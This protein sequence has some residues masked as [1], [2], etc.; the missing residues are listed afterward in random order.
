MRIIC[1]LLLFC[2]SSAQAQNGISRQLLARTGE[3]RNTVFTSLLQESHEKCDAV[4]KTL[5]TGSAGQVDNWEALCRNGKSF[6]IGVDSD[7][8]ASTK[9]LGCD[10]MLAISAALLKRAGSKRPPVGCQI[11]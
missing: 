9:I 1:W 2:V 7:P 3:Q 10:E 4:I 6:S 5:Y 11:K 8:N